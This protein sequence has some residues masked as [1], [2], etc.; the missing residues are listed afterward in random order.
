MKWRVWSV[1]VLVAVAVVVP[2][3]AAT[4]QGITTGALVGRLMD[5]SGAPVQGASL[6]LTNTSTG[7]R[8]VGAS[9]A[10]GRFNIEN[11]AVGGPYTLRARLIGFQ[12]AER[13]GIAIS[14]GQTVSLDVAMT[15]SAVELAAVVV[16]ATQVDQDFAPSRQGTRTTISDSALRRLPTL[17]RQF[18]D[19]VQLTPQVQVREGGGVAVAG[20]NNLYNSIQIDG[21]T[22]ND[23]FG[24]GRSGV[25]G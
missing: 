1:C 4:A 2:V 20:Q 5:E 23:R 9:R 17:N 13:T 24:L 7:Q 6:V 16:S 19:F 8:Y 21:T 25:A 11:V 12:P 15:R 18:Q 3:R 10:D 22:L 14:L